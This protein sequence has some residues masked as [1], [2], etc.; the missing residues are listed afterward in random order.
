MSS[1][2]NLAV[3]ISTSDG[4]QEESKVRPPTAVLAVTTLTSVSLAALQP[5]VSW[6]EA[7][8]AKLYVLYLMGVRRRSHML[9]PQCH[10]AEVLEQH[11][12][13]EVLQQKVQ[14]WVKNMTGQWLPPEQI[15]VAE[16]NVSDQ[17]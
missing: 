4:K 11:L 15:L 9:F 2:T 17:I 12:A 7:F 10:L 1:R 16:G 6:A 13:I 5:A 3:S 14:H 8:N